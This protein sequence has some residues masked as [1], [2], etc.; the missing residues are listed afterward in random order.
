MSKIRTQHDRELMRIAIQIVSMCPESPTD[1]L[2][3][4]NYARYIVR[5][6]LCE[7]EER[8]QSGLVQAT[9]KQRRTHRTATLQH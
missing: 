6:F 5:E 8:P 7:D 1:A 2:Q 9:Q 3:V 4:L